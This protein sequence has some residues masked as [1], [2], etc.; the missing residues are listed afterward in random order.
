MA[1]KFTELKIKKRGK[2]HKIAAKWVSTEVG[3]NG[4]WTPTWT[5]E[6]NQFLSADLNNCIER[7]IP[8]ILFGAEYISDEI[9]LDDKLDYKKWFNEHQYLD[10]ERFTGVEVTKIQFIGNEV[11]DAVKIWGHKIT[12]RTE[13]PFKAPLETPVL[14]LQRGGDYQ[15]PLVTL[16]DEHMD[17]LLGALDEWLEK[18][19]T[20]S[21]AEQQ[22]LF[23][24]VEA[25]QD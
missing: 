3:A 7:I 12:Q 23:E 19:K 17:N 9:N 11:L 10:D 18:G 25:E 13:K 16:L 15:Y 14:S 5:K 22:S 2:Q 21:K 8:H 20:L 4:T 24:Q 6:S 1:L